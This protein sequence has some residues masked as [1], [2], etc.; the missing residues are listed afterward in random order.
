MVAETDRRTVPG[1]AVI[2]CNQG[3]MKEV[4]VSNGI[5]HR[6]LAL[7][8]KEGRLPL[9]HPPSVLDTSEMSIIELAQ[10][11]H[12]IRQAETHFPVIGIVRP[13]AFAHIRLL[14]SCPS[15]CAVVA[16][17]VDPVVLHCVLRYARTLRNDGTQHGM[18]CFEVPPLNFDQRI[19]VTDLL[20]ALHDAN[21]L[22]VV[23]ARLCVSRSTLRRRLKVVST[24]LGITTSYNLPCEWT[25]AIGIG[26][27]AMP[28][29]G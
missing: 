16:F 19:G 3:V 14:A 25:H 9:F 20:V 2:S 11:L 26:L 17:P 15:M 8:D 27:S 22:D 21:S 18:I 6:L 29:I 12:Q 4:L 7:Q 28:Y 13:R 23:Q 1:I 24:A 5:S 10:V